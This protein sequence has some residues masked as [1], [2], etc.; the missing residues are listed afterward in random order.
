MWEKLG[1]AHSL[2]VLRIFVENQLL[3]D[4]EFNSTPSIIHIDI[5]EYFCAN[6]I[7]FLL[8]YV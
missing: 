1:R 2:D 7:V 3:V 6:T 8:L 4:V 5:S